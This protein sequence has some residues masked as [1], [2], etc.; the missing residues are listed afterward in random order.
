MVN[1]EITVDVMVLDKCWTV[2]K[3]SKYTG[4]ENYENIRPYESI[5]V[6]ER[7]PNRGSTFKSVTSREEEETER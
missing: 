2:R 3:R 1:V 5:N 4:Y 7:M 6:S